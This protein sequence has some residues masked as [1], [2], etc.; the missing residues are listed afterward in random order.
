MSDHH[1]RGGARGALW[2]PRGLSRTEAALYVGVSA[3]KFDQ[4]VKEG[5]MPAP[6]TLGSRK[7]WDRLEV[8]AA[9]SELPSC[10]EENPWDHA[11]SR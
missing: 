3:A 4:M 2:P 6:K 11:I 9:F 1:R 7:V 5:S 10:A 8:D